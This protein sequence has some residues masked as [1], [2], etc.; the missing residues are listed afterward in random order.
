MTS[1]VLSNCSWKQMLAHPTRWHGGMAQGP[2]SLAW[3]ILA[4]EIFPWRCSHQSLHLLPISKWA[5]GRGTNI[6]TPGKRRERNRQRAELGIH[7]PHLHCLGGCRP[8]WS[9]LEEGVRGRMGHA[10]SWHIIW[11]RHEEL[12]N[13]AMAQ[14][15][16]VFLD[17]PQ[18]ISQKQQV[19][20]L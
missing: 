10:Q 20:L 1:H 15:P 8:L 19:Q 6:S 12:G 7:H 11:E 18:H 17:F 2:H 4:R 13:R 16:P 3:A 9:R 5:R 14:S